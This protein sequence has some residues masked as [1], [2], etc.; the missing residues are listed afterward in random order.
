MRRWLEWVSHPPRYRMVARQGH[1]RLT[2]LKYAMVQQVPYPRA[3]CHRRVAD[4]LG[5][6]PMHADVP[7]LATDGSAERHGN[8]GEFIEPAHNLTSGRRKSL[9]WKTKRR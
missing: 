7:T 6:R 5:P 2:M 4:Q 3:T 1:E 9:Q 8:G